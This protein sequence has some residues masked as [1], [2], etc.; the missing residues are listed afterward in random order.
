MARGSFLPRLSTRHGAADVKFETGEDFTAWMDLHSKPRR[1][2]RLNQLYWHVRH[3]RRTVSDWAYARKWMWQRARHGYSDP[4]LWSLDHTLARLIIVGTERMQH[5]IGYPGNGI[6]F[7]EWHAV[8]AQIE[9]GFRNR[10][11]LYDGCRMATP[12][13]DAEFA[14]A[15]DLLK[16]HFWSLWD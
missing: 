2:D 11:A 12:E 10:V 5:G 1:F 14:A 9:T 8:L 16:E 13:D 7:E 3:P 6:T 4:D 15:F